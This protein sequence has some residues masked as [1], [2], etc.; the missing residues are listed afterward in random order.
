[1]ERGFTMRGKDSCLEIG[2]LTVD[3]KIED[4]VGKTELNRY[5]LLLF[6][7]VQVAIYYYGNRISVVKPLDGKCVYNKVDVFVLVKPG[8]TIT[9]NVLKLAYFK[10][11]D[12]DQGYY[13]HNT[14]KDT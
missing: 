12:H 6:V 11:Q 1:M 7:T 9:P 13:T 14:E 10:K 4:G 5:I 2:I 8:H 3:R